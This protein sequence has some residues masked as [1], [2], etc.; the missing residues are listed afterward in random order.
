MEPSRPPRTPADS[1]ESMQAYLQRVNL[2]N[3]DLRHIDLEADAPPAR[4]MLPRGM[5]LAAAV[6]ALVW[7]PTTHYYAFD[8]TAA[9]LFFAL[10]CTTGWLGAGFVQKLLPAW[11][12]QLG[13]ALSFITGHMPQVGGFSL[14]S[15]VWRGLVLAVVLL[16]GSTVLFYLPRDAQW[17]GSGYSSS[18]FVAVGLALLTGI[19]GG[20]W[21]MMQAEAARDRSVLK[22]AEPFV[23]PTWLRWVTLG[24]LVAGGLFAT[25]GHHLLGA[26]NSNG[27]FS[28]AGTGFAVGL[29]GAIWMARRFDELEKHWLK[30]G[31]RPPRQP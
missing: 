17:Q 30:Q 11:R 13:G 21:L 15:R 4:G 31:P 8:P 29:F 23:A 27:N 24:L 16:S 22:P 20:R 6:V 28:M 10:L 3:L 9:W 5:A 14:P 1:D 18:W 7:L 12:T 26:E 19:L 25:F 2:Q